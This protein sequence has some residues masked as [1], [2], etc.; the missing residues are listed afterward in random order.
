MTCLCRRQIQIR[1]FHFARELP[2]DRL[3]DLGKIDLQQLRRN[4][5]VNH[6]LDQLAQLSLR[7]HCRHQ[8]VVR[9]CVENQIVAQLVESQRRVEKHGRARRQRLYIVV[10]RL[11]I[12]RDQKVDL[13]LARDVAI[14]IGANGVPGR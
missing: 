14:F 6:I 10:R 1:R 7:T 13:L 3:L 2:P 12:H 4:S 8:F 5:D 9:D 11:H